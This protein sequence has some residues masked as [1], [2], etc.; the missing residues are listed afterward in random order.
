M[1]RPRDVARLA[2]IL[3][4]ATKCDRP[5][6]MRRLLDEPLVTIH[7]MRYEE[8]TLFFSAGRHPSA[9]ELT[10]REWLGAVDALQKAEDARQA[11]EDQQRW[12]TYYKRRAEN[13][14]RGVDW[15][16]TRDLHGGNAGRVEP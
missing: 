15:T 7:L 1:A 13:P 12:L 16:R 5:D 2:E 9:A 8:R 6:A 3:S 4:R 11:E 10:S 14:S